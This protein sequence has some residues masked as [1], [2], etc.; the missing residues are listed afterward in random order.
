MMGRV[1]ASPTISYSGIVAYVGSQWGDLV[2]LDTNT[3]QKKWKIN[4]ARG[5]T[6]RPVLSPDESLLYVNSGSRFHIINTSTSFVLSSLEVGG[7]I[8]TAPLLDFDRGLCYVAATDSI[9]YGIDISYPRRPIIKWKYRTG[10][11]NKYRNYWMKR[12]MNE[13]VISIQDCSL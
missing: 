3:G 9:L 13:I 8:E 12:R 11:K 4:L 1:Q 5:L 10:K 6:G 7:A 2:A